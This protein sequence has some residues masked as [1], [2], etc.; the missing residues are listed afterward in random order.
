M[1]YYD[2]IKNA[3]NAPL[4]AAAKRL[5]FDTGDVTGDGAVT[6]SALKRSLA[7]HAHWDRYEFHFAPIVVIFEIS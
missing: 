5:V 2:D 1:W 6:P 7:L 4:N 3:F